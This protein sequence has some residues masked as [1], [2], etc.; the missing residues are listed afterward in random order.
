MMVTRF[1]LEL[2]VGILLAAVY[3]CLMAARRRQGRVYKTPGPRNYFI[4]MVEALIWPAILLWA[5]Q[6]LLN[7]TYL[8]AAYGMIG[9]VL[10]PAL[11]F[12]MTDILAGLVLKLGENLQPGDN[13]QMDDG[14]AGQIVKTGL[15]SLHLRK[16]DAAVVMIP[17]SAISRKT[18]AKSRGSQTMVPHVFKITVPGNQDTVFYRDRIHEATLRNVWSAVDHNPQVQFLEET[19]NLL[20]FQVTAYPVSP[21]HGIKIESALKKELS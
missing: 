21:E 13:I 10:I 20:T 11:W 19:E 17:Y 7:G 5:I 9:I 14:M 18:I 12:I 2:F 4:R 16:D 15:R 8:V 1:Y 3:I 6:L